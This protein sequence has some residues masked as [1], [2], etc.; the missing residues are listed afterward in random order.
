LPSD[1]EKEKH[2]PAKKCVASKNGETSGKYKLRY[3]LLN[4]L[5]SSKVPKTLRSEKIFFLKKKLFHISVV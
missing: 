1:S 4:G 3:I 2:V 5:K